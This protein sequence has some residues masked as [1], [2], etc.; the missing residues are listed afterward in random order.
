VRQELV[1]LDDREGG[2]PSFGPVV[3]RFERRSIGLPVATKVAIFS[4]RHRA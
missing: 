1:L 3:D 4:L 2:R